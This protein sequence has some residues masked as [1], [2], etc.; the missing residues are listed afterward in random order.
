ML[1]GTS[2]PSTVHDRSDVSSG[3]TKKAWKHRE[4]VATL[5]LALAA[6]RQAIMDRLLRYREEN[7]RPEDRNGR[8]PQEVA[9]DR[10]GVRARQWQRWEKGETV[11]HPQNLQQLADALSI[12]IEEFFDVEPVAKDDT[13][14]LLG[15]VSRGGQQL[16]RIE[17]SQQ[18]LATMLEGIAVQ[19]GTISATLEVLVPETAATS[20]AR[21]GKTGSRS[22]RVA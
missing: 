1:R 4:E 15:A 10:A 13:P 17:A 22:R 2:F 11:P 7:A 14:D 3:T 19:L 6:K 20:A 21:R 12:P 9:A 16:D 5:V 18:Q 8:L